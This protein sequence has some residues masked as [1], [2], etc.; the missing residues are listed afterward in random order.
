[1]LSK[2]QLKTILSDNLNDDR[3]FFAQ[4]FLEAL[5]ARE[6]YDSNINQYRIKD[7]LTNSYVTSLSDF[8]TKLNANSLK[9]GYD[10]KCKSLDVDKTNPFIL[11]PSN[12]TVEL[13][14]HS[15]EDSLYFGLYGKGQNNNGQMKIN[16][17][18]NYLADTDPT[19]PLKVTNIRLN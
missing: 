11:I 1:M 14:I 18:V 16:F 9:Y 2:A 7:S 19:L 5:I 12:F 6:K 8:I 15:E 13:S 3:I 17:Y 10:Y 4:A